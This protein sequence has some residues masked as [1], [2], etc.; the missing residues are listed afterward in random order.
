MKFLDAFHLCWR[1]TWRQ[2]KRVIFTA[3]STGAILV[4]VL[5][6]TFWF[7]GLKNTY[8]S[9]ADTKPYILVDDED[10]IRQDILAQGGEILGEANIN[11]EGFLILPSEI[12]SSFIEIDQVPDGS[13]PI[14]LNSATA[15]NWAGVSIPQYTKNFDE[16]LKNYENLREQTLGKTFQ[17]G[18]YFVVG[19]MPGGFGVSSLA[20]ETNQRGEWYALDSILRTISAPS[21]PAVAISSTSAPGNSAPSTRKLLATFSDSAALYAYYQNGKGQELNSALPD[22]QYYFDVVLGISPLQMR[23]FNLEQGILDIFCG[24]LMLIAI[25]IFVLNSTRLV[26]YEANNIQLYQSL[27]ASHAQIRLLFLLKFSIIAIFSVIFAIFTALLINLSYN[28]V[29]QANLSTIFT[30]A[31]GLPEL[32]K[33]FLLG[34]GLDSIVF[35]IIFMLAPGLATLVNSKKL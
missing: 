35:I 25:F 22:K 20:Y 34:L 9:F 30:V 2:K 3:I 19:F 31:F 12:V 26:N 27:G 28:L 11:E 14:L 21:S 4:I 10:D 17:D 13:T 23:I 16:R 5:V 1:E 6:A 33:V 15:S 8:T 32:P 18:K 7:Q 24:A 29:E